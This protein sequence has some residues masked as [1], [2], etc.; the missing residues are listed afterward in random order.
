METRELFER[1]VEGEPPLTFDPAAATAKGRQARRHR[2]ERR[3]AVLVALL[4]AGTGAVVNAQSRTLTPSGQAPATPTVSPPQPPVVAVPGFAFDSPQQIAASG[5]AADIAL[6]AATQSLGPL[7]T[8][9]PAPVSPTKNS[10]ATSW[11]AMV[12][13]ASPNPSVFVQITVAGPTDSRSRYAD[14]LTKGPCAAAVPNAGDG[15]SCT[16]KALPGGGTLWTYQVV[17]PHLP[18]GGTVTSTTPMDLMQRSA[19][20]VAA[21]G[22]AL[23]VMEFAEL[24]GQGDDL[25]LPT[26]GALE[27]PAVGKLARAAAA[28]WLSASPRGAA[29]PPTQASSTNV[30][31]AAMPSLGGPGI[32]A[33]PF[34]GA[35]QITASNAAVYARLVAAAGGKAELIK[36]WP[37]WDSEPISAK[38]SFLGTQVQWPAGSD[39][40][41]LQVVTDTAAD[42][43]TRYGT[44]LASGP[45]QG[46]DG[47]PEEKPVNC[48]NVPLPGGAHA[49][50]WEEEGP[51]PDAN[52][53]SSSNGPHAAMERRVLVIARDGSALALTVQAFNGHG[54]GGGTPAALPESLPG[55]SSLF[56]LAAELAQAWHGAAH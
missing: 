1:L 5:T 22:S 23:Q 4:I 11:E 7:V 3:A 24:P 10:L 40:V 15:T 8:H 56:R 50:V 43:K 13:L 39:S 27:M 51:L 33:L 36:G 31:T 20:L 45:C 42:A 55:V 9:T 2:Y 25:A 6:V 32:T 12:Q 18:N 37:T 49:W 29:V 47:S 14:A 19:L 38:T 16:S 26:T 48:Q 44:V 46:L 28:A 41:Y 52:G 35:E 21:D 17:Q 34:R 54:V 30:P 53:V